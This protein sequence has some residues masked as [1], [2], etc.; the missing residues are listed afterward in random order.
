MGD[1]SKN[2][3]PIIYDERNVT[4]IASASYLYMADPS[5]TLAS[6]YNFNTNYFSQTATSFRN[7]LDNDT[8]AIF[9]TTVSIS[10][11]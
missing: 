2:Q 10:N 3:P 7:H 1:K 8:K 5:F 11:T 9:D 6:S 4:K